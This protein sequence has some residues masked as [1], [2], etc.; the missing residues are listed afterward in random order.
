MRKGIFLL[1][2]LLL[3]CKEEKLTTSETISKQNQEVRLE[4]TK[5]KKS[6]PSSEDKNYYV[7]SLDGLFL[8]DEPSIKSNKI[9]LIPYNEEIVGN[10]SEKISDKVNN[11]E[12]FWIRAKY[13][14]M[15]G[16]VFDKFITE[17][18]NS[19]CN[20]LIVQIFQKNL[21]TVA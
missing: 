10:Y 15:S 11:E 1:F 12:G 19:E 9:T 21:Q 4:E 8:R 5:S 13:K 2:V 20:V 18:F 14:D 17:E 7:S 3:S 6:S 16:W